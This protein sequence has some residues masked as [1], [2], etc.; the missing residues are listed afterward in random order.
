MKF[1]EECYRDGQAE[2]D[3]EVVRDATPITFEIP[4]KT[5]CLACFFHDCRC[6]Q[7]LENK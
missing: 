4:K 6:K 1:C 2:C 7:G 3:C 5:R